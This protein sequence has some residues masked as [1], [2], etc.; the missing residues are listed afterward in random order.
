MLPRFLPRLAVAGA[1]LASATGAGAQASTSP[2]PPAFQ[3]RPC[4]P[5]I[6]G[7]RCGT[8][9]VPENRDAPGRMLALNVIVLPA[10]SATPAKE[11]IAFFG[12]GPGQAIAQGARWAAPEFVEL[13][14]ERDLLFVDQRGTG[15][16]APLQC[17]LRDTANP[18][19]YLDD[20][21]P[22]AAVARCRQE[23]SRNADLTRY[24]FEALAHDTEAV[25]VALG[26]DKLNL[27]GGS[28]GTRAAM[29]YLRMYPQNVR[30][31]VLLGL[32]PP[33]FLQPEAYARD[34]D[35]ALA[36]IFRECRGDAACNAAFPDV[37][38]EVRVV[39]QR[40]D[41][42]PATAEIVDQRTGQRVRLSI[43][44][45]TFAE[46]VRR[47]MY[48]PSA[49]RAVPFVVH[50]AYE[51]DFRPVARN[52]LRD[53]R[54]MQQS[55]WWGL[56]LSITCSEDVPFIDLAA[57]AA[58]NGRTLLG[59][60]RVRQQAEAC[61]DWPRYPVPA[62]FH[63]PFRSDVPVLLMSGELDPV[64]PPYWGAKAAAMFPNSLHFVVP[65]GGHGFNGMRNTECI[66]SIQTRF[67]R[68]ASV[69]GLDAASCVASVR[70]PPFVLDVPEAIS[71]DQA[72]LERLAGVYTSAQPALE[73]RVEA[74]QGVLR[75]RMGDNFN[76]IASPR[77]PTEF[78][79]EGFPPAFSFT[80]SP[81]GRT[82]TMREPAE[83]PLVLTRRP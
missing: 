64:T 68:Q 61:R 62:S 79:W 78:G 41:E 3:P 7:A 45:G 34:T 17:M 36:G 22:P 30:S 28:Y 16:S 32:V 66:D 77:S 56:F 48:D 70:P 24:G 80:F 59:D 76:M 19:S 49:A 57:A 31:V 43:S 60:Y 26:Y 38:R 6:E 69:Q 21:L 13:M 14:D 51:G 4:Q 23:L 1:V 20:F 46:T 71:L 53:R 9:Q 55:S 67:V 81:D 73:M 58:E 83:Q 44:R 15:G 74:L 33:G 50:R 2:A 5:P 25:R 18:Q 12:G 8:V 47:M 35:A 65:G 54:G 72:V 10:R 39:V 29:S 27:N 42:A 75:M 11:A 82:L 52:A 40:L 63:Q 37:E